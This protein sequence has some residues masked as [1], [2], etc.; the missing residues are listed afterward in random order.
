MDKRIGHVEVQLTN[1]S[2]PPTYAIRGEWETPIHIRWLASPDEIVHH[3]SNV[4]GKLNAVP[5][6]QIKA[7]GKFW[8]T[9]GPDIAWDVS[10]GFS[11]FLRDL[12]NVYLL[13]HNCTLYTIQA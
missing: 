5:P 12:Y 11:R 2:S 13:F 8:M 7:D 3:S 6:I 9:R 1:S 4:Y 10:L